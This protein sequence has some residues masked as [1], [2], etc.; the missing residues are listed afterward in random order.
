VNYFI[1][2][3]YQCNPMANNSVVRANVKHDDAYQI[4]VYEYAAGLVARFQITSVLELGAGSGRKLVKYI[5]P[6]CHDITG[7]D[8]P[9]ALEHLRLHK[10]GTWMADDFNSETPTLDRKFGMILSI[11]VIEHLLYPE[12]LLNKIKQYSGPETLVVISTPERD[13]VRG[14]DS[15]GPPENRKHVREWN[16]SE[17]A[18]FLADQGFKIVEHHVFQAKRLTAGEWVKGRLG[19]K[20]WNTCQTVLAKIPST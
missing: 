15:F 2:E 14:H 4:A 9:S 19:L 11:D 7:I 13:L 17:L 10:V 16:Q 6:A 20:N 8:Q 5:Y 1:K 3:G 12:K 18:A